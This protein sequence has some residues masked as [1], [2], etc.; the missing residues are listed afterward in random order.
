[1]SF[2]GTLLFNP[3]TDPLIGS[4]GKEFRFSQPNGNELPPRGYDPGQNTFQ[5]PP[6]N[7]DGVDVAVDPKSDRLQLLKPFR[8]WD[9]KTPEDLPILIKVKG[10]CSEYPLHNG[11]TVLC[12]YIGL[13]LPTISALVDHGSNIAATSR[14]SLVRGAPA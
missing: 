2:A 14:T 13:Q 8:P 1:M 6:P 4:D 3:L 7:R 5:A 9:G 11:S 10:K 12:A